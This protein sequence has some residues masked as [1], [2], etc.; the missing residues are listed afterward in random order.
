M[1]YEFL[2]HTADLKIK[3]EEET[4]DETFKTAALA[5]KQAMAENVE[6]KSKITRI[7]SVEGKDLQ[8]LLY[9]FM[10][11]FIFLLDADDFLLSDVEDLEVNRDEEKNVYVLTSTISGDN[12]SN[13]RFSNDV[14][15]VTFNEMKIQEDK[16]NNKWVIQFVLDV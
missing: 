1:G 14:K 13:Y 7:V 11:E 3:I 15:A 8:D 12:A 16:E 5:I 2:D 9:N 6:V 4:L 10:E